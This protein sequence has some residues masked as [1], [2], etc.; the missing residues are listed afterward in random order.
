MIST[1]VT[2]PDK[3]TWPLEQLGE[4]LASLGRRAGLLPRT[5]ASPAAP[6]WR[7]QEDAGALA[8]WLDLAAGGLGLEAEPVETN[9]ADLESLLRHA[10]PLLLRLP[11]DEDQEKPLFLALL[12]AQGKHLLLLGVDGRLH[13]VPLRQVHALLGHPL[14]APFIGEFDTLLA[15]TGI[16]AERRAGVRTALLRERLHSIPIGDCWL[17]RLSPA[18]DPWLQIR[19][20]RLLR[21]LGL[22]FAAE[23]T[24]Q[25]LLVLAWAVIGRGAL[26]GHFE[27]VWLWLWAL[28][29]LSMLPLKA[30][31]SWAQNRF[32]LE[33]TSL[34]RQR[35]LHGA[36][37]LDPESVRHA[38]TGTFLDRVLALESLEGLVLGGGFSTL[39]AL[40]Q[41]LT[42]GVVLAL[43][44]GGWLHVVLLGGCVF[45]TLLAGWRYWRQYERW[46]D[47]HRAMTADLV[48]KMVGHRT[49][50]AQEAP[51]RWH[52][53][54]DQLLNTYLDS[55]R[56]LDHRHLALGNGV[57]YAW[58][59]LGL[60]GIAYTVLNVPAT[61]T[62]V[63]VGVGGVLLAYQAL[64]QLVLGAASLVRAAVAWGEIA[65]LEAANQATPRPPAHPTLAVSANGANAQAEMPLLTVHHLL[66]RYRPG[67]APVLDGCDLAIASGERLL[68]EGPSGGGKSTL[69]ALLAGLRQ[70]DGGL[71]LL[72][73]YDAQS[74]GQESWRQRVVLVPQFHENFVLTGT[75]AFNL[76]M[77][78][79]WPPHAEDLHEAEAV[80]RELGLGDLLD[81]M[82]AGLMQ[83]V[84]ESGWQLS[85][86]ERS[87]LY[88]ARALLQG[89]DLLV[90]DESFAA[91]DPE[92]LE[93]ALDCVLRRAPSLLV[94][95][96][97]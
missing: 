10:G 35:L 37:Q 12:R 7:C 52:R 38:G 54:E 58:L 9:Y 1:T 23:A 49:R 65:P 83:Q 78:R 17:L 26:T 64:N 46:S 70:A 90:L 51:E 11:E 66:F 18:A 42:A 8:H 44:V 6:P 63:A 92:N 2:V 62:E 3:T 76:L 31:V 45:Y 72:H 69:A 20:S 86:G 40:V 89:A 32:N 73:G 4:A 53:D 25:L 41:L 87:R 24:R 48:E 88:V 71:L 29:L 22:L 16:A 27:W 59:L 82:P 60:G 68:L 94:I 67:D 79:R 75:L 43:G 33:G 13:R 47:V 21:P 74:L 19:H 80:C 97:P 34:L 84:G 50:L 96:H 28:L 85:H 77:G 14:E 56:S 81:R 93:Q 5:V 15:E 55:T 91:L 30:V 39:V 95:A 57:P 61:A 36:L